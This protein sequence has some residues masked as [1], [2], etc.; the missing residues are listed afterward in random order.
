MTHCRRNSR[1]TVSA[2]SVLFVQLDQ[3]AAF[4]F[5]GLVL[6]GLPFGGGAGLVQ[7]LVVVG[8]GRCGAARV[9]GA[10]AVAGPVPVPVGVGAQVHHGQFQLVGLVPIVG[11]VVVVGFVLVVVGA[12]VGGVA[13]APGVLALGQC[14]SGRGIGRPQR[15]ER[16]GRSGVVSAG[17]HFHHGDALVGQ[18]GAAFGDG[19]VLDV[20][21][22][23]LRGDVV[24]AAFGGGDQLGHGV[25]LVLEGGD[26]GEL[27][28][29]Q[30]VGG[31]FLRG[32]AGQG[33]GGAG[34]G[35]VGFAAAGGPADRGG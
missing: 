23:Q 20:L 29:G 26:D 17:L 9:R 7:V 14:G 6:P 34:G 2:A 33:R 30:R 4:G 8:V 21:G 1:R 10:V 31:G 25:R 28:D 32:R 15:I 13:G 35:E 5:A 24:D 11:I 22:A 12:D 16:P 3:R 27:V 18:L 19:F